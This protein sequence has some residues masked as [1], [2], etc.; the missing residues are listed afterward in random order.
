MLKTFKKGVKLVSIL[1]LSSTLSS[2]SIAAE[3]DSAKS[4][5]LKATA[6]VAEFGNTKITAKE[7]ADYFTKAFANQPSMKDKSLLEMEP[8]M[9]ENLIKGY[10]DTLLVEKAAKEAGVV[11][12]KEYKEKIELMKD[13]MLQQVYLDSQVKIYVTEAK[14]KEEYNKFKK[15]MSSKKEYKASHILVEDEKT[16]KEIKAKLNKG[17]KFADLAKEF[18]KDEGS[19]TK[20]GSLGYFGKGQLVPEFESAVMG[21]KKGQVSAPVKS[22]FGYHIILLE[23]VRNVKVPD[24]KTIRSQIEGKLRREAFEKVLT[25]LEKKNKVKFLAH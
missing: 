6:I 9:R 4:A 2:V 12:T 18:S 24:L 15:E 25:D 11:N 14:I 22:Q 23:D 13:Q 19:K 3:T 17:V 20:G 7:V 10:V 8:A 1:L 16:A 5:P 21:L